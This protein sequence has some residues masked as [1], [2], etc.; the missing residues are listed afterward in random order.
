MYILLL[1]LLYVYTVSYNS[2]AYYIGNWAARDGC[3]STAT[4]SQRDLRQVNSFLK[5][6][7]LGAPELETLKLSRKC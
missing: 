6:V 7:T 4:D 3:P 1:M 2:A 5:A